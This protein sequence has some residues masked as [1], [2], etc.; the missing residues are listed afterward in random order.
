MSAGAYLSAL[1]VQ[2]HDTHL[3]SGS[4]LPHCCQ[5]GAEPTADWSLRSPS[6]SSH[7]CIAGPSVHSHPGN[8]QELF[9]TSIRQ[10]LVLVG[11]EIVPDR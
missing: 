2:A 3:A 7:T 10:Q 4:H 8:L 5:A 11:E 9:G 1:S 6:R